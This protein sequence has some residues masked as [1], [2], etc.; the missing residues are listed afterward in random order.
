MPDPQR[1]GT[2]LRRLSW[3]DASSGCETS[4]RGSPLEAHNEGLGRDRLLAQTP[5]QSRS[6]T[7]T[8]RSQGSQASTRLTRVSA[9]YPSTMG[10]GGGRLVR[11]DPVPEHR[12]AKDHRRY[13]RRRTRQDLVGP[14]SVL[15]GI[16]DESIIPFVLARSRRSPSYPLTSP[17]VHINCPITPVA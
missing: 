10:R 2:T 15:L 5:C 1:H 3:V 7:R 11:V 12:A 8:P 14:G 9:A 6:R 17:P 16:L 13:S 4:S